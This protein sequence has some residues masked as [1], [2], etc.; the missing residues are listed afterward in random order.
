MR[1]LGWLV[2]LLFMG[3]QSQCGLGNEPCSVLKDPATGVATI[4]CP[5]GTSTVVE[6]SL[7]GSPD[8]GAGCSVTRNAETK[9]V[10][11]TCADGTEATVSDGRSALLPVA[12]SASPISPRLGETVTL[13]AV[14]PDAQAQF[15]W[16]LK[17]TPQGSTAALSASS[18]GTTTLVP[19]VAGRYFVVLAGST[20]TATGTASLALSVEQQDTVPPETQLLSA[21]AAL[22]RFS[23][24]TFTFS[25]SEPGST[26]R[27]K[28]DALQAVECFSPY[29]L[30]QLADGAHV[31]AVSAVD[32]AGNEDPT[33]AVASFT[34]DATAPETTLS[35]GPAPVTAETTATFT[36]TGTG[37]A[38]GF[39]CL[40]D[41]ASVT[42]CASP[43]SLAG[44]AEGPHALSVA[45]LDAAGNV[46][47]T[48]AVHAWTVDAAAPTV[49]V[50][51]GPAP[52]V[53][54]RAAEFR[55]TANEPASF[56]CSL[57]GAPFTACSSPWPVTVPADG[58]HTLSVLARDAAG[59]VS[60]A[61]ASHAW[62][63][64]TTAPDTALATPL[65]T[66]PTKART[67]TLAFEAN[68]QGC[69]FQCALDSAA[70]A[71]CTSPVAVAGLGD[72]THT[73]RVFAV[74]ALG[75]ADA[76]PAAHAWVVDGAAPETLLLGA[77]LDPTFVATATFAFR[78]DEP[79]ATFA[80]ALDGAAPAPCTSPKSYS[81]LSVGSHTF[82]V[83]ATDAVGNPDESPATFTWSVHAAPGLDTAITSGPPLASNSASATFSFT[84]N[85]AASFLCKLD[86]AAA[87]P[88]N[89][90]VS[91]SGL[92]EGAHTLVVTA[93]DAGGNADVTPS[94]YG[95]SVD[96]TPPVSKLDEV[97]EYTTSNTSPVVKFSANEPVAYFLCKLGNQPFARCS[98]PLAL[99]PLAD[100]SHGINVLAV[101]L[102][103]NRE[104]TGVGRSWT[105]D[106]VAPG[107]SLSSVPAALS[108][109]PQPWIGFSSDEWG[110]TFECSL[111]GA[112]YT[113]CNGSFY[114]TTPLADGVHTFA[115]RAIDGALNKDPTPAEYAWVVDQT[116]P[117]ITWT[118]QPVAASKE[119]SFSF[120]F[121]SDDPAATTCTLHR[122]NGYGLIQQSACNSPW[123][124]SG[125]AEGQYELVVSATDAAGNTGTLSHTWYVDRTAPTIYFSGEPPAQ[126]NQ[127]TA[128][129]SANCSYGGSPCTLECALDGNAAAPCASPEKLTGLSEGP[130]S[131]VVTAT[132][133]AGNTKSRTHSWTV[134][135]TP[136]ATPTNFALAN[137]GRGWS[138]TWT[139]SAEAASY[140][141]KYSRTSAAGPFTE[142]KSNYSKNDDYR[143]GFD[144]KCSTVHAVLVAVDSA[145][146]ESTPTPVA[147]LRIFPTWQAIGGSFS[148]VGGYGAIRASANHSGSMTGYWNDR[149]SVRLYYAD[150][151]SGPY[152]STASPTQP[153]PITAE[154]YVS[155]YDR[156]TSFVLADFQDNSPRYFRVAVLDGT[157][158]GD[159]SDEVV[160]SP[161]AWEV[162][163]PLPTP[164][165]LK[166]VVC[167]PGSVA[168]TSVGLQATSIYSADGSN[169]TRGGTSEGSIDL[170]A[171]SMFDGTSGFALST[172]YT[173][174]WSS[175]LKKTTN[176]GKLW[177]PVG[178]SVSL[179]YRTIS[180][181]S[182]DLAWVAGSSG[183]VFRLSNAGTTWTEQNSGTLSTFHGSAATSDSDVVLVGASGTIRTTTNGGDT[184][185]ARASGV[186]TDLLSVSCSDTNHCWAV[187]TNGTILA[188][189]NGGV[190]WTQQTSG[191]TSTLRGVSFASS[192]VGWAVGDAGT[193]LATVNGGTTWTAQSSGET[194]NLHSVSAASTSNAWF[195][196][197]NGILRR[198]TNGGASWTDLRTVVTP[199]TLAAIHAKDASTFLASAV[200]G[201]VYASSNGG[202]SFTST[203]PSG[204]TLN[205]FWFTDATTGLAVGDNGTILQTANYGSSWTTQS[206]GVTH[207]LRDVHCVSGA[208][209]WVA[210]GSDLLRT[211]NGGTTW[212][213][214]P[215]GI[216]FNPMTTAVRFLDGLTG[217]VGTRTVSALG[218]QNIFKT[219]DSG[220]T[221]SFIGYAG[222]PGGYSSYDDRV[223][224]LESSADPA[225]ERVVAA[226]CRGTHCDLTAT[227]VCSA[228]GGT[229]FTER[230]QSAVRDLA[231]RGN[232]MVS[233][234]ANG[235]VL[236]SFNGGQS[237]TGSPTETT[238]HLT[239]VAM[240]S[241]DVVYVV[242]EGGLILKSSSFGR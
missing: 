190:N 242:G 172:K 107:T 191:T 36:F 235:E 79:G 161:R 63:V 71:P 136:P 88:C 55:F 144:W 214:V 37:G 184:W 84:G 202:Q 169:W 114:P 99:G 173:Y 127:T 229:N 30:A 26:F 96:T 139:D 98:S 155:D 54:T 211:S 16:E 62:S 215:T 43:L 183:K 74:D 28:V 197:D 165:S 5:D 137:R 228:P 182:L 233:A 204:N 3:A 60:T 108:N 145:G 194:G 131:L 94:S 33:P 177:V 193:V 53:A 95:W 195:V 73:F 189:S 83:V 178:S 97:P 100:G 152:T 93:L 213:P 52:A 65:P 35:G 89:S 135:L 21:P 196:G 231:S 234:G 241:D 175:S 238:R 149:L 27:C 162:L 92:A 70:P 186:T 104:V 78:S 9:T 15:T 118:V 14:S 12:V 147:S 123:T 154:M 18:G 23:A 156:S 180:A 138:A 77:P 209:C 25:A 41:G 76:V 72:G 130:H 67:A 34:V 176:A 210:G 109:D 101:D 121:T 7:L 112:A 85:A 159:P 134:D 232:R 224:A 66:S 128:T 82:S 106:T 129:I 146:N 240:G 42:P 181:R 90:P 19:D 1:R 87:A 124:R 122:Y 226:A 20:A 227:L 29:A 91:F 22:T 103:G 8:A 57:D 199:N 151:P 219:T 205:S 225:G 102:A 200:G 39:A 132:D 216:S 230:T 117:N 47:D 174:G 207:A 110:S 179:A 105:V 24:A 11:V 140:T 217:Y 223:T 69:T 44:L 4:T 58:A 6:P 153:S 38:S 64:D 166:Q 49:T 167:V 81:G 116:P 208:D 192:N 111:D 115:V 160:V 61:P 126:S 218:L 142:L 236:L 51:S 50:S 187:G 212:I 168:C 17:G 2:P 120:A 59:N 119:S 158:E 113:P 188:T 56:T 164:N 148:I 10:T 220:A 80:C 201:T 222:A 75:N 185:V 141:V 46:D 170:E 237:W 206:S 157:C 40:L 239:G 45:A 31:V 48:P 68:E 125:M 133:A 32:P 203:T 171:V 198:T 86:G 221:W 163:S 13:A 150:S 143:F